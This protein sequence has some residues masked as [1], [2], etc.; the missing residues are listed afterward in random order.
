M[1]AGEVMR[2]VKRS[3]HCDNP[4]NI[5]NQNLVCHDAES[6]RSGALQ[7]LAEPAISNCNSSTKWFGSASGSDNPRCS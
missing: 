5:Q 1:R 7:E 4:L 2:N 6:F 3:R